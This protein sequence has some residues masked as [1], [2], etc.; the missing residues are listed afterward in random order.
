MAATPKHNLRF[1][2]DLWIPAAAKCRRIGT[3][4]TAVLTKAIDDFLAEDDAT[5]AIRL[6]TRLADAYRQALAEQS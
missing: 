3:D 1:A 5:S 4:V 6:E 2:D